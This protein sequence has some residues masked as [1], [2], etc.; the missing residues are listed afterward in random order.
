MDASVKPGRESMSERGMFD[1][2]ESGPLRIVG[3]DHEQGLKPNA[4]D[5]A[6]PSG[7]ISKKGASKAAKQLRSGTTKAMRQVASMDMNLAK[8]NTRARKK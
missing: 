5:A 1:L 2:E 3:N 6:C 7:S 8:K 4:E